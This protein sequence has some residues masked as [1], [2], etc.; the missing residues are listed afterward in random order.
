MLLSKAAL[1]TRSP[2]HA[3]GCPASTGRRKTCPTTT[4]ARSS[5]RRS[6]ALVANGRYGSSALANFSSSKF[7]ADVASVRHN[8]S[9][10]AETDAGSV[11]RDDAN[12]E[13]L[14]LQFS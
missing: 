4:R 12:L 11:G 7:V 13:L 14:N 8:L 10:T 5:S 2:N 1:P 3:T 6:L 9:I